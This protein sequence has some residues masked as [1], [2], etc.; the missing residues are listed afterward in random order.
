[1]ESGHIRDWNLLY[2][3]L[4]KNCTFWYYYGSWVIKNGI[5]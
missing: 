4:G 1:M 5:N 2:S 3:I